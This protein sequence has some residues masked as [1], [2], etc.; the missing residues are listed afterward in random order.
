M[1]VVAREYN[2]QPRDILGI[3]RKRNVVQ[4]RQTAMYLCRELMGS[5]Y[6]QL[7]RI[8]GGKDHS[9]VMHSIKKIDKMQADNKEM[10]TMLTRLK[11][12]CLSLDGR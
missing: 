11:K 2:V 8:F 10:K 5:S 9:T 1:D 3:V 4:A 6:P 12:T 7:G